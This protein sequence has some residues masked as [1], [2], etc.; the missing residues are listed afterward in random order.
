MFRSAGAVDF[1]ARIGYR[2]CHDKALKAAVA[3]VHVK[4]RLYLEYNLEQMHLLAA[5]N[6]ERAEAQLTRTLSGPQTEAAMLQCIAQAEDTLYEERGRARLVPAL[7]SVT[8]K[9]MARRRSHI[10][11]YAGKK[12]ANRDTHVVSLPPEKCEGAL[13]FLARVGAE[14]W[15]SVAEEDEDGARRR[16]R[17]DWRTCHPRARECRPPTP[18]PVPASRQGKRPR[19]RWPSSASGSTSARART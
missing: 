5:D 6:Y 7:A 17:R 16:K 4:Q 9:Q 8:T 19:R 3:A 15:F 11:K 14:R 12:R 10:K 2:Y 13:D 18:P 1:V